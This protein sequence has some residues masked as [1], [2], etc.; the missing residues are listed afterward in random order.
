MGTAPSGPGHSFRIRDRLATK[1]FP[2][3]SGLERTI[4]PSLAWLQPPHLPLLSQHP[5]DKRPGYLALHLQLLRRH[6]A[7]HG[8]FFQGPVRRIVHL[9]GIIQQAQRQ[10]FQSGRLLGNRP[11]RG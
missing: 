11:D 2:Y 3:N 4:L 1:S 5:E 10:I 7:L 8:N 9:P 6:G